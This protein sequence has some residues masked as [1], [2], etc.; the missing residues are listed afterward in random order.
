M[1][2]LPGIAFI[3][4]G[5]GFYLTGSPRFRYLFKENFPPHSMFY[6]M[7]DNTRAYYRIL[8]K[9]GAVGFILIG[10]KFIFGD[11]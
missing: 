11:F 9:I 7:S 3:A 4:A 6:N 2:I 1:T 10:L 8:S 5:V